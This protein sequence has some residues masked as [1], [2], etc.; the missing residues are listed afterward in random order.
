MANY[1]NKEKHTFVYR[2]KFTIVNRATFVTLW[3]Q[4]LW[5][6][7]D[8]FDCENREITMWLITI[9]L[10]WQFSL[11]TFVALPAFRD[12]FRGG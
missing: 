11:V 6:Y 1:A 10:L 3:K 9:T 4:S 8:I 2:N 5:R 7:N 12:I